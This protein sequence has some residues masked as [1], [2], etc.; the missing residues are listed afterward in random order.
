MLTGNNLYFLIVAAFADAFNQMVT[1]LQNY[2]AQTMGGSGLGT[3]GTLQVDGAR[4]P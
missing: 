1:S 2:T 4:K 3:G